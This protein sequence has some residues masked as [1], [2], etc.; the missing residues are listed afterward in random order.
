MKL[1][2]IATLLFFSACAGT[3]QECY[4]CFNRDFAS[5]G[6]PIDFPVIQEVAV[7]VIIVPST[8]YM[9]VDGKY[10]PDRAGLTWTDRTRTEIYVQGRREGGKI[11]LN[12]A[13]LG[14]ELTHVLNWQNPEIE[15]PDKPEGKGEK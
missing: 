13:T 5:R 12:S 8:L 3:K 10:K 11:I 6:V 9:Q 1:L 2:I 4:D 15:N 7:R 14:H